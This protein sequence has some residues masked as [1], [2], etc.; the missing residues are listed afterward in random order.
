MAI[1]V[2]ADLD[3][4]GDMNIVAADVPDLNASKIT[5]GTFGTARI[6]NLAA[7]KITSGTLADARIASASNWNSAYDNYI[8]GIAVTGTSTKTITLTQRDGGTITAD[9]TDIDTDNNTT[10][11]GGGS[12][13]IT[14]S[15]TE[16]RLEDDRRRNSTSTDIYTGN[17][18]DYT[19]YDAS[20][21]IRWYTAGGEE[22]R[23]ENDGDL[24]VDGD[25][26]AY[27]TTVSDMSLKDD[28]KTIEDATSKVKQLRGVMYTWNDT[29][30][31]GERDMGVIA[32]EVEQVVPEI[33]RTKKLPFVNNKEFKTVDYEKLVGLLIESNKELADRIE[34]LEAK[35][36]GSSK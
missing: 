5:A 10:Y 17:T 6:P 12:Y 19:F 32:Q 9:F 27:S 23:L 29:S 2:L 28:I 30:R 15:G 3:V 33:V 35:L 14:I 8:T 26:I 4:T 1:Q 20:H 13:G 25:V 22:M 18:H 24:H 31:K 34:S 16:I 21:G 7:S 36:Y 11:T